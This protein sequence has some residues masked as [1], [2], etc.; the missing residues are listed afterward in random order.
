MADV[1][2][3]FDPICPWAW[4]TSRWVVEVAQQRDLDVWWRFIALRI[5][6]ED[7]DYATDFPDGYVASHGTGLKLLRVCAAAQAA[8]GPAVVGELYTRFG[9]DIHVHGKADEIKADWERGFP[10]YLAA[11]GVDPALIAAANDETFDA[12]LRADTE[13]A[14]ERVGRGVGTP[15]ITF[16][17]HD[18]E[19]SSFFGP[20]LNR[21]PRGEEAV[22]LWDAVWTVASF[23]G[24]SELKRTLRGRPATRS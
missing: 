8:H 21:V 22:R 7:K 1:E 16:Y 6:N 12:A 23:P 3:F 15:I 4:I 17:A 5:L 11:A 24:L 13:A 20:V 9:S 10:D 14:L 18:E 2:F 19:P